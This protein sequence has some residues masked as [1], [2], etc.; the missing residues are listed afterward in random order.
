[1]RGQTSESAVQLLTIT[2]WNSNAYM[3]LLKKIVAFAN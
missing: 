1:M 2:G 3:N